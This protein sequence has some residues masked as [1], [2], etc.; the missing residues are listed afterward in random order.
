MRPKC[1]TAVEEALKQSLSCVVGEQL[2]CHTL[3]SIVNFR[4]LDNTNRDILTDLAQKYNVPIRFAI[5]R[6]LAKPSSKSL[7]RCFLFTASMELAWHNNIYRAYNLPSTIASQEVGCNFDW[8]QIYSH[9]KYFRRNAN[10][11]PTLLILH[12]ENTMRNPTRQRAFLRLE[13]S[14]GFSKGLKMSRSTGACGYRLKA[15]K[16]TV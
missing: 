9:C 2:A 10:W 1:V 6:M 15:N 4:P 16:I 8:Y 7:W 5:S 12:F 13:K 14:I 11:F 3:Q